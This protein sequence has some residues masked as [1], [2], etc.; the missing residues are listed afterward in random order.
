MELEILPKCHKMTPLFTE[1][2]IYMS[3]LICMHTYEYVWMHSGNYST[4]GA[5]AH[6]SKGRGTTTSLFSFVVNV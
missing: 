2:P 3:T 6:T 5:V 4:K 1:S